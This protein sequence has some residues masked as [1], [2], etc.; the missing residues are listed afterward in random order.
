MPKSNTRSAFR[1]IL[2]GSLLVLGTM[3]TGAGLYWLVSLPDV[4]PLAKTNPRT[5]ALMEA[6]ATEA[7]ME[8]HSVTPRWIWVP[9]SRISPH[10]IRA[11]ITA[12]DASFVFHEGFDWEGIREA[13]WRDLQQG[14]LDRGGSTITQQLAK[15]LYLSS[16]KTL[17]RKLNEALIARL[18]E[19]H[20][21][22]KRILELYLNVVEWGNHV[23]GAEAAARHHFGKPAR[24][25]SAEEAALLAAILPAPRSNDPLPLDSQYLRKRER[26]ILRWMSRQ[27]DL[28][29]R[30]ILRTRER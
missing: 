21:S 13:A 20:L 1:A 27:G 15:N 23:Y 28:G 19:H 14:K 12:E 24:D 2:I 8:G 10:L 3:V 9:L 30:K 16:D 18:L 7:Q 6:R 11:V 17:T 29:I 26:Q 4:R 22:K 5:T 25:L